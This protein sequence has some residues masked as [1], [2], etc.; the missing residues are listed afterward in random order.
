[1]NADP[2]ELASTLLEA[3]LKIS[4]PDKRYKK[5]EKRFNYISTY[6]DREIINSAILASS[7]DLDILMS[8]WQESTWR[9]DTC[10]CI[11]SQSA[12]DTSAW[13]RWRERM[14]SAMLRLWV[15]ITPPS[16]WPP[17]PAVI[18]PRFKVAPINWIIL[19][20]NRI[21]GIYIYSAF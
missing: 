5:R 9:S 6:S 3:D 7:T 14:E 12:T 20:I 16:S 11:F 21:I 15:A 10:S 17:L 19:N 8:E 13:V 2:T 1:M 4:D 18:A